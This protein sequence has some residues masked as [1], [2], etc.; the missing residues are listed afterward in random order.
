MRVWAN[1]S[2]RLYA[3][4]RNVHRASYLV[5]VIPW[6]LAVGCGVEE[7][8]LRRIASPDGVVDT[9]LTRSG[10]GGATVGDVYFY[11]VPAAGD[12]DGHRDVLEATRIGG[13]G[14]EI[15]WAGPQRLE[16]AYD[17]AWIWHFQKYDGRWAT[18]VLLRHT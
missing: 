17:R 11:I 4:S 5:V 16:I 6:L 7:I 10:G 3:S 14:L 9:V 12:I 13:E 2:S 15:R 1:D 8:E 18:M